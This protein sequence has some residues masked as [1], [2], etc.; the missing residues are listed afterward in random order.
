[1]LMLF[2]FITGVA[3][4]STR[5]SAQAISGDLVGIVADATG[6]VVPN[7]TVTAVNAATSIRATASTNA[8]GFYRLA[9]LLPGNYNISAVATGF[10]TS[11]VKEVPV[12]LNQTATVNVTLTLGS[13]STSVEV[14]ATGAVLDTTTAQIET[15]YGVKQI[16]DLPTN[17]IGVGVINLSLLEAGVASAGG[18]GVG[19]G[20]SVGGQRPRNNNFTLE[21]VDNNRKDVTGP[22]TVVPSES[23]AEFTLLQNQ[24]QA[25]YGHSS[26]G[27]FNTIVKSGSN[28]FHAE[29]YEYIENRDLNAEDQTFK[30]QGILTNPRFDR[31]H[32]GGN[33]GGPIEKNKL[34][35]FSSFEYNPLGQSAN[36]GAP[37]YAPTSAGYATLAG[38]PGVSQTNLGV[39]KQY[40]VAPTVTAGAPTV[41]VGGVSVPTG[42]IPLAAPNFTNS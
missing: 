37:V 8:S 14:S 19:T 30:T 23:V 25:E 29:L 39:L 36:A 34:F 5:L 15:T 27:Q 40:A 6:A 24:F 17:T 11:V 7:A 3:P 21:G 2:L 1:M 31:N 4:F 13:V 16:T 33:F 22:N 38:A 42:I 28:Q 41:T 9:N 18:I 20:P 32:L 35:F 10:N 26:G 12:L